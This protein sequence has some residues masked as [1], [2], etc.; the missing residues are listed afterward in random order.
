M[1]NPADWGI[2]FFGMDYCQWQFAVSDE[3][4]IVFWRFGQQAV[5]QIGLRI[6]VFERIGP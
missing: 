3:F 2:L 4:T 5:D 1:N 6:A